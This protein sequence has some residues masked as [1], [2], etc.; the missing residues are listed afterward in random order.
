MHFHLHD[1]HPLSTASPFG[2]ADHLSFLTEVPLAFE[3]RGR[4]SA[5]PMFGPNGLSKLLTRVLELMPPPRLSLTLEIHPTGERLPLGD[6]SP[7]FER[8]TDRTNAERMNA[9]L[10]VLHQNHLFL[11]QVTRAAPLLDAGSAA[12]GLDPKPPLL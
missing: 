7:L 10:S 3:H 4:R 6:A 2:V 9:W 12:A 1:A 11:Q 5:A 8:W